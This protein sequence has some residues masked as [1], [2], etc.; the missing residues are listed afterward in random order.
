MPG[1]LARS[2]WPSIPPTPLVLVPLGST[3]QHGPHLPF[4]TDTIV[5]SAVAERVATDLTARGYS[6]VV[7]P[8]LPYGASGEH[9]DFPGTV[10]IGTEALTTVI[11]ELVRSLSTWAGRIVL[12]NG[13]GGNLAALTAAVPQLIGEG[14]AVAWAPC[15]VARGDAH[16]GITET[17]ILLCLDATLVH[18]ESAVPGATA[19]MSTLSGRLAAEGVRSVSPTGILGDPTGASADLGAALLNDMCTGV[20]RRI[21]GESTDS[22]GCLRAPGP[23]GAPASVATKDRS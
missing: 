17:S 16:A 9:Q 4:C 7:A 20:R 15:A 14:H 10:S 8:A 18:V 13:H 23:T 19:P 1:E 2:T 5:A 11:V 22:R 6:V 12:I 3:E 21:L